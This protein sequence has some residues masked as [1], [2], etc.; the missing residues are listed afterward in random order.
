MG[1]TLPEGASDVTA[2]FALLQPDTSGE[3]ANCRV[4]SQTSVFAGCRSEFCG[5]CPEA[6]SQRVSSLRLRCPVPWDKPLVAGEIQL[7]LN[8]SFLK[9]PRLELRT[10]LQSIAMP[11]HVRLAICV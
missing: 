11:D 5:R 1:S 2:S 7:A 9:G 4:F 8:L 10:S 6:P 3:P